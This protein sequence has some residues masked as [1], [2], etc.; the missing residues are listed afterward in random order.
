MANV[1]TSIYTNNNPLQALSNGLSLQQG[2]NQGLADLV[3]L[4][5]Q[6]AV[7]NALLSAT[8]P[9]GAIDQNA[10]RQNM[11]KTAVGRMYAPDAMSKGLELQR[12]QLEN[13]MKTL[14]TAKQK[15]GFATSA[16]TPLLNNPNLT[17]KDILA[18][19]ADMVGNS[20][21][22]KG[23]AAISAKDAL[24]YNEN[25]KLGSPLSAVADNPQALNAWVKQRMSTAMAMNG[26]MD[27]AY[28]LLYVKHLALSPETQ[29]WNNSSNGGRGGYIAN[30][31]AA[32][33]SA[34]PPQVQ[35]QQGSIT[36]TQTA[37]QPQQ[38][39]NDVL[40][41]AAPGVQANLENLGGEASKRVSETINGARNSPVSQ[42]INKQ[43][44]K[45]AS[46]LGPGAVGPTQSELTSL[47]GRVY[48]TPGFSQIANAVNGGKPATDTAGK[49]MELKKYL[50]RAAQTRSQNLG[51]GTDFQQ[52]MNVDASP[53]DKQ[54]PDV[55][56]RLAKYNLALD[57]ID[58]G[59]ASA[60]ESTPGAKTD[61]AANE[62]F[63]N[64]FRNNLD[65]NVYRALLASPSERA[66]M[67]KDM[68]P[69]EK[70]Q[71]AKSYAK[72]KQ[73]NAIPENLRQSQ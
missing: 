57:Y 11:A 12:S 58:Q 36:P 68:N 39:S 18:A 35:P 33:G 62:K 32:P 38:A 60:L 65:V 20:T 42:D 21:D 2:A 3:P 23:V 52:G 54:F 8:G 34:Q 5:G 27:Q 69:T 63:E 17:K 56:Q 30:V 1:D 66:E 15:I 31:T 29:T 72:L 61:P 28:K 49:L 9:D 48:D 43:A 59:K 14:D 55:I 53:N 37:Q 51:L 73:M 10:I 47:L 41:Q 67:Y 64:D 24:G 71:L 7:G 4:Q 44:I 22:S 26:Q 19:T 46:Q 45:L 50:L 25:P 70:K 16:F 13:T 40:L 6:Q